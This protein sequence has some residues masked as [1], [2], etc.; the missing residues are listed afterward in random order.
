MA[1]AALSYGLG[2]V[3]SP[4]LAPWRMMFLSTGLLTV[5]SVPLIYWKLGNEPGTARFLTEDEQQ[6]AI[7]RLRANQAGTDSTRIQWDQVLEAFSDFKT[8]LFFALS[9]GNSLGAQVTLTFGPLVFNGLGYGQHTALLFNIPFGAL[10]YM[11]VLLVANIAVRF[12]WQS[13]TLGMSLFPAIIGL[14]VLFVV[15]HKADNKAFLL[16]GYHLLAFLLSFDSLTIFWILAN[17]AGQTKKVTMMSLY[18]AAASVGDIVGPIL[19]R[20]DDAP[21]YDF[22]LKATLGVYIVVFWLVIILVANLVVLNRMQETQR[23]ARGKPANLHDHSMD[24]QYTEMCL[25]D[26]YVVGNFAFADLTDRQNDEFIYVH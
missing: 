6:M 22:G 23:V 26:G 13:L 8:Y 4:M 12:R 11:I 10:Q 25:V 21:K 2:K 19:F 1:G 15:P 18:T 24:R 7:E 16:V 14:V 9:L 5:V 20:D 17:T 3:K